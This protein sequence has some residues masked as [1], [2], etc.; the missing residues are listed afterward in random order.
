MTSKGMD[1]N[2]KTGPE[3]QLVVGPLVDFLVTK[4]WSREQIRYGHNE[5]LVPKNPSEATK[6]ES[7]HHYEGFPVDIVVFDSP[8]NVGDY[9]HIL[10]MIECKQPDIGNG[11][12]QL[13]TYMGLEPRALM[14]IWVN[15]PS[16]SADTRTV[17]RTASG[18]STPKH[19]LVS[20][21]P[22]P[23]DEICPDPTHISFRDLI[24][25]DVS[26]LKKTFEQILSFVVARDGTVTR[27]ED[28]LDQLCNLILLKLNS[29]KRGSLS[30]DDD[31]FF[32]PY[33]D[34]ETTSKIIHQHFETFRN[35][36][37]DIFAVGGN[38]GVLRLDDSTISSSVSRLYRFN[39]L[40]I[41]PEA[42]STAFQV[43]RKAALKQKEGQYFTPRPVIEAAVKITGINLDDIILDPCCGTGG[44]L[45][46]CLVDMK[47]RY[48]SN[49]K[50]MSKW[51]QL[52]LFGIDKD[53]VGIKL[54]KAVMQILDDGSAN[55][56]RGDSVLTYLWP[57]QYKHL[58]S[59]SYSNNRFTR[60]FTNPPFGQ[61]VTIKHSDA[62]K[63]G[64]SIA[65]YVKKDFE[66][67]LAMLNRCHDL[68]TVGGRL[69]II[70]PETYFF[71]TSYRYV[72]EWMVGRLKPI[73]M[74]NV[75]MDAFQG[76]CR[77]KTNIYIFEKIVKPELSG[78]VFSSNPQTC[79][80]YKNGDPRYVV[81]ADGNRTDT[82]D[83]ALLDV[84]NAYS[85]EVPSKVNI[86][87]IPI[88]EIVEKDILVPQYYDSSYD[89][90]FNSLITKIDTVPISLGDLIDQGI[91]SI[92]G[93]HG[94]P[95]NDQR[96]GTI[97][98][99]KVSDIR[100]MRVNINPTNLI[101][102]ELAKKFW[103]TKDGKSDLLEW[104]LISPNRASSNIGEFAVLLPGE[105][106]I[107]LTKEMIILRVNTN[108]LG[109][110]PFYMLW[111]LSLK[112][113]R[114]EW[115]RITLMQTN[116]EDVGNRYREIEI[117]APISK[118]W[119]DSVSKPFQDYLRTIA[120]AKDSFE[121]AIADNQ[122]EY[123]GSITQ[124][125]TDENSD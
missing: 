8:D 37:P 30:P 2:L 20:D 3:Q 105:E 75:P 15:D 62:V 111:A 29:D 94:S 43:L 28:Q 46:Q 56:V 102:M 79:G 33:K 114:E 35:V 39:M 78:F 59:N 38:N 32:R 92:R 86:R 58:T 82:L 74:V 44:F 64:L 91:I 93:G 13:E 67:G 106:Q 70:L 88:T 18:L 27:S 101:P 55:C 25:P 5:W 90:S 72:R 10:F 21:I 83:N 41:G 63:S 115:R 17:F 7:G 116:R 14:G 66:L 54:T 123:I 87:S 6:R 23:G 103:R 68:L 117:P 118:E 11:I 69:C 1:K 31:V 4:G 22:S 80:I 77:A 9:R 48:P 47:E 96:V 34:D 107:V 49:S 112:S 40:E 12:S 81:D 113:V 122:F 60:I 19:T 71:S 53:A 120:N 109:I 42:V 24:A 104:D 57:T 76:F 85:A 50:E 36:Y 108:D 99:I 26:I 98:Y 95:G 110:T 125:G 97:P 45:I 51:A 65:R 124:I 121:K 119:A 73:G 52:H 84:A 89:E 100:N 61:N 16:E